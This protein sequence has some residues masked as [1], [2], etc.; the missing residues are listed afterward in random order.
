VTGSAA[1]QGFADS[2]GDRVPDQYDNCPTVANNDQKDFDKDGVGDACDQIFNPDRPGADQ[3]EEGQEAGD[4]AWIGPAV[5]LSN[6]YPPSRQDKFQWFRYEYVF[7]HDVNLSADGTPSVQQTGSYF[8]CNGGNAPSRPPRPT[9]WAPDGVRY[10]KNGDA[11][12]TLSVMV[13]PYFSKRDDWHIK[14]WGVNRQNTGA[15]GPIENETSTLQDVARKGYM[16]A[17]IDCNLICRRSAVATISPATAK[18]LGLESNVIGRG[19][20]TAPRNNP[21]EPEC[22]HSFTFDQSEGAPQDSSLRVN[23]SRAARRAL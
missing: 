6:E 11:V 9:G 8:A 20:P 16:R 10:R 17:F 22:P 12:Y 7:D 5:W 21:G 13:C 3:D 1:A 18:A 19:G 23:V 15:A 4:K 2:D 14:R